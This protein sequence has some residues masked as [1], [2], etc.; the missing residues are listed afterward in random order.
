MSEPAAAPTAGEQVPAVAGQRTWWRR[1]AWTLVVL[2]GLVVATVGIVGLNEWRTYNWWRS[3]LP[4][5]V[6]PGETIELG[7]AR[8]GPVSPTWEASWLTEAQE[9]RLED[10]PSG[11]RLLEVAIPVDP[12]GE[13]PACGSPVLRETDGARRQWNGAGQWFYWLYSAEN[14]D[15]CLA[16]LG[17]AHTM[18]VHYLVPEDAVGPFVVDVEILDAV[19][20]FPRFLLEL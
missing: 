5:E 11:T 6:P 1:N 10:L 13:M 17:V 3:S 2:L 14:P 9:S 19:P 16:D 12:A 7:G 18:V 15:L 4:T 20:R 8:W